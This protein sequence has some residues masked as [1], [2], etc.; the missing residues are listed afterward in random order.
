MAYMRLSLGIHPLLLLL[1]GVLLAGGCSW[2]GSLFG[3][4]DSGKP[5]AQQAEPAEQKE[6]QKDV[7]VEMG[8]EREEPPQRKKPLVPPPERGK[9]ARVEY[10]PIA[11]AE[12][13]KAVAETEEKPVEP[14]P[15]A[16]PAP[17]RA[18]PAAAPSAPAQPEP[19][20]EKAEET[21]PAAPEKQVAAV[22]P[23]AEPEPE[24]PQPKIEARGRV[25]IDRPATPESTHRGD[26]DYKTAAELHAAVQRAI[27]K[28]LFLGYTEPFDAFPALSGEDTVSAAFV[29]AEYPDHKIFY[30]AFYHP[31]EAFHQR[32]YGYTVIDMRTNADFGHFDGNADGIFEQKTLD[33]KIVIEDYLRTS[34]TPTLKD[35]E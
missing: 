13:T 14:A 25:P 5:Q 24:E 4:G 10:Q 6:G 2:T 22:E 20:E 21:P 7:P 23:K 18:E 28:G 9:E 8:L 16:P 17:E 11:P 15:P 3:A 32:V 19:V 1:V 30:H 27:A 26:I 34:G 31:G 12:E 35:M 29:P 33:P